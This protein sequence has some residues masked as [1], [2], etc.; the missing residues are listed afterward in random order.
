ME[1]QKEKELLVKK[2]MD[3]L[4]ENMPVKMIPYSN[5]ARMSVH[6]A[7]PGTNNV[8]FLSLEC[9][10]SDPEKR[11]LLTRVLKNGTDLCMQNYMEKGTRE[12]IIA[13]LS[14]PAH[15]KPLLESL[16]HLSEAIDDR[17]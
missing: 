3:F 17:D 2:C 13:Y 16:E 6:F 10:Y 1:Y 15:V 4:I 14:D 12:E 8:A 5:S 7:F 11:H 9:N